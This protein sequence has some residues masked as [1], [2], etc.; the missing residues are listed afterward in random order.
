[1]DPGQLDALALVPE[2]RAMVYGILPLRFEAGVLTIAMAADDENVKGDLKNMLGL[3]RVD[4][5]LW[6]E[7]RIRQGIAEHYA[8]REF[9]LSELLR[10]LEEG[11]A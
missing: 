2:T 10:R 11:R 8:G 4:A 3:Y 7:D 5:V 6:P 9:S 1:M